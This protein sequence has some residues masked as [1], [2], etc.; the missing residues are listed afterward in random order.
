MRRNLLFL[1]V[2]ILFSTAYLNAQVMYSDD[3]ESYTV[4]NG[5][6][7]EEGNWWDTWDGILDTGEDPLV[8]D[9]YAYEGSQ[10]IMVSGVNDGVIE[11]ED[12]TTGRYRIEFYIMVPEGTVGYYNIMQNFN[13]SGA[14]LVWGMQVFIQDGVMSIDG[15][16]EAAATFNYTPG[17]WFK[18]QHFIDLNS[19]WVDMYI[20][21][22]LIHAYQW[23]KGTF[24]DGTGIVKLDA[25]DFYA[26]DD[27][28]TATPEYYMDNFLIE[29]VETPYAPL[30]FAYT[31]EN[32]NDVVLTWEAPT[33]GAPESYAIARDGEVVGTT[34]LL[35]FTDFGV[36]PNTY[37]YSLL[38]FYGTSSGYSAPLSVEVV[39]SG[40]NERELVVFEIYTSVNCTYCPYVAQAIDI[41]VDEGKDVAVIE[42]HGDGLG[43]DSYTTEVTEV[44]DDFYIAL[45]PDSEYPTATSFNYP[46]T[47]FNGTGAQHG[48]AESVDDMNALFDYYYDEQ[49][50]IPSVYILN[51]WAEPISADP[52]LF[53]IHIDVEE[54]LAYF[55]DDTRLM[56]ALTETNIPE[57][58]Q[59]GLT[60]VNFV[61]RDMYPDANGTVL[62]FSTETTYSTVV[63]VSIDPTWNVDNC[64][65]VMFVQNMVTGHIQQARKVGLYTFVNSDIEKTF[66][67]TIYPNPANSILNIVAP[68]NIDRVEV[69]NIAGQIVNVMDINSDSVKLNVEDYS[70]GVYF[71][72]VFTQNEVST[73]KI[74]VE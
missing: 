61:A 9:A 17:E 34:D 4:G 49:I 73:H 62:D 45:Y 13:P 38:A 7:S 67:T 42:Y 40:G 52:Y 56:V 65:V 30:N 72:K 64:E 68:E 48:T 26:W 51:T 37:E 1:V 47:I 27:D 60:E 25:F 53:N 63:P 6:A 2:G 70:S 74:I 55:D 41:L 35:T 18:V 8:T 19:D 46:T 21:D 69:L 66:E 50:A 32:E 33:E 24:D 5:I 28:G 36:Y 39:I 54:T 58:W 71:V 3:F 10:S 22:E 31:L 43:P 16:G 29:E 23:S 12:L 44:R 15:N 14:G 59:G 11:F 57:T 20:N